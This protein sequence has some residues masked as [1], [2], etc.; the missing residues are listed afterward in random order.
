[1]GTLP[2]ELNS[3]EPT[4]EPVAVQKKEETLRRPMKASEETEKSNCCP[5]G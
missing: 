5:M 2:Q 3:L 4:R 1:M